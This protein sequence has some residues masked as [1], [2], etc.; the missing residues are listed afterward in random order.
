M[1][2]VLIVLETKKL[3]LLLL[4]LVKCIFV[5][6]NEP[7]SS[8][9]TNS[10]CRMEGHWPTR[11]RKWNKQWIH[12]ECSRRLVERSARMAA[13]CSSHNGSRLILS[14]LIVGQEPA[15]VRT[16][17]FFFNSFPPITKQQLNSVPIIGGKTHCTWLD[18]FCEFRIEWVKPLVIYLNQDFWIT[19]GCWQILF[20]F[21]LATVLCTSSMR[22]KVEQKNV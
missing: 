19:G 6:A 8:D 2:F 15:C 21:S 10:N 17:L 11:E 20:F 14:L 16:F 5:D 3:L 13:Q 9:Q 18:R 1:P 12:C 7:R 4:L 22:P